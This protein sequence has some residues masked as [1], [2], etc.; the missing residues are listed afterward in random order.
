V[1][2]KFESFSQGFSLEMLNF[3]VLKVGFV[4]HYSDIFLSVL[5][6]HQLNEP[7]DVLERGPLGTV[8]DQQKDGS[9]HDLF[10]S[11]GG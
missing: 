11:D 4:G 1:E 9:C 6:I 2:G 3:K 10:G 5:S 8:V 7:L